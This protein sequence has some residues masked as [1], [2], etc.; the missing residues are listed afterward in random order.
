MSARRLRDEVVEA[1]NPVLDRR[2]LYVLPVVPEDGPFA[3]REGIA[4]RRVAATTGQCPCGAS[5]D[6]G[7][8]EAGTVGVGEVRHEVRCPAST[9]R[10]VKAV[11]RWAR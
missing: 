2:V 3:V 1:H 7:D 10:L 9:S 6:Y 4:R 11:R 8:R 5:V